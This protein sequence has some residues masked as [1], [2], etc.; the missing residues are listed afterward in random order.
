MRADERALLECERRC[1]EK[2]ADIYARLTA[3]EV[4][5]GRVTLQTGL[6]IGILA[7]VGS[8]LASA[9]IAAVQ[10]ALGGG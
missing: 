4:N 7:F 5:M 6:V 10:Q 3:L 1:E 8:A 9:A 2:R